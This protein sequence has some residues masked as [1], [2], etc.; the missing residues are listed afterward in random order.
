[1]SVSVAALNQQFAI[2]NVLKFVEAGAGVPVIE[3]TGADASARIAVQ[4]AQVLEWQPVGQQPVLWVSRAA[5]YQAG[6]GVRG[7]VP[8]CWPWFGAGEAG[9]P[10]HGFVRTRMWQVRETGQNAQG[11]F[12]KLGIGDDAE[13]RSLWDHAFDLELIV[14]AGK[15]LTM[16]L[17]T[18]N[19]CVEP[20]TITDALHTYFR[21]GDITKTEVLG[22]DNTSYLDKVLDFGQATQHGAVTFSGETDRV[23]LDTQ[24]E[25]VINDAELKR[26][27]Y[28]AKSGSDSTVVWNPWTEK[29]KGF[30]DM[31]AGEYR[32]MLCVET[33][34]AA[35]DTVTVA[36]GQSHHLVATVSVGE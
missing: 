24:A 23:Y 2:P 27:I 11:V 8:V 10:A 32:G 34:N 12:V 22:L 4:G 6:K 31:A 14:V 26:R 13:T 21:T 30:A 19:T 5:I 15:I 18:H 9:K 16:E 17:V 7:G 35:T 36:P 25:C 3:I 28:V 33:C 1:M 20:F 29:E